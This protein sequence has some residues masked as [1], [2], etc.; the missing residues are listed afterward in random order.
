MK[1]SWCVLYSCDM[2]WLNLSHLR[3]K[4]K[5]KKNIFML[6][7]SFDFWNWNDALLSHCSELFIALTQTFLF[8]F[9]LPPNSPS[10]SL[11]FNSSSSCAWWKCA[12]QSYTYSWVS[13][14]MML[15]VR[16]MKRKRDGDI[17]IIVAPY[18]SFPFIRTH[19]SRMMKNFFTISTSSNEYAT[20]F[21][22]FFKCIFLLNIISLWVKYSHL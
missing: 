14:M 12:I 7:N 17:I 6:T 9:F 4:Q 8:Y 11:T 3:E 2:R 20:T 13:S 18:T 10:P 1:S 19:C 16:E 5:K 15:S 22:S 21:L